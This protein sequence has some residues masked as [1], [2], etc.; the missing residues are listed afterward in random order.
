MQMY[1]NTLPYRSRAMD[2]LDQ[3][4]R[5][6]INIIAGNAT[7]VVDLDSIKAD[8]NEEVKDRVFN[9]GHGKSLLLLHPNSQS[10]TFPSGPHSP[11]VPP[12]ARNPPLHLI[13][14]L[15]TYFETQKCPKK[16]MLK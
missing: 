16:L 7:D 11:G 10:K 8:I 9:G 14:V 12:S 2:H 6:T 5:S 4:V 1:N 3:L 15:R 13:Q